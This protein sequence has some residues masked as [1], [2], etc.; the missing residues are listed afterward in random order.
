M[1]AH[2]VM[3][4]PSSTA[5]R[6]V[7]Q[8]QEARQRG[9]APTIPRIFAA[10]STHLA[11]PI[12]ATPARVALPPSSFA[13]MARP[14][15]P[16]AAPLFLAC[17]LLLLLLLAAPCARAALLTPCDDGMGGADGGALRK[18]T[19]TSADA[20]W[21]LPLVDKVARDQSTLDLIFKPKKGCKL[22]GYT[23]DNKLCIPKVRRRRGRECEGCFR[24]CRLKP[25]ANRSPAA[26]SPVLSSCR[27]ARRTCSASRFCSRRPAAA[28]CMLSIVCVSRPAASPP[29]T[30]G[31]AP[32]R[33]GRP[34]T[35]GT[36]PPQ[37][38]G[39]LRHAGACLSARPA[40]TAH[41][42]MPH[43]STAP[44]RPAPPA[45]RAAT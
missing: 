39:W 44:P 18:T 5:P 26:R 29:S 11:P 2:A 43:A 9:A 45:C 16:P 33:E 42:V 27:A 36:A 21:L 17:A 4:A 7:P 41:P 1:Q 23:F 28:R 14:S 35:A 6:S 12:R 34:G 13:A 3:P 8:K 31:A 40:P 19:P 25:P 32:P 22:T 37:L 20:R 10:V 24:R 15:A 30:H 38:P